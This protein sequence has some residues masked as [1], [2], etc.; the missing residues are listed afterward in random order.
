MLDLPA[1]RATA[2]VAIDLGTAYT[3]L[4]VRGKGMVLEAPSVVATRASAR[5]R[6]VVAI[7]AEAR[8]MLGRA[9]AGITVE[10]PVRGG[11]VANFEATEL[12]I[13]ALL[14]QAGR[15]GLMRPR[16]LVC[17]PPDT[18]DVERRA[19]QESTRAAGA[20]DVVLVGT[21]L[22]A[23]L[24]AGVPVDRP[25]GSIVIDVGAGR[26]D[27]GVVSLGGLV[28]RRSIHVA[29]DVMDVAITDWLRVHHNLLVG[30]RTA[31]AVK[32]R[33]GCAAL[34]GP[35]DTMRVRG[36]DLPTG[37][38]RELDLR[39]SEI[40]DALHHA[41]QAIRA[42]TLEA[43]AQTPPEVSADIIDRGILLAGGGS[44]L[45]GLDAMLRDATGLPVLRAEDA[46]HCVARG[47][48]ALLEQPALFAR[49]VQVGQ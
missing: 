46:A 41:V 7:G 27:V 13:R 11:I 18:T 4:V 48:A 49:M 10:R 44:G 26:T 40:G 22:V 47:A 38:P 14:A 16:V 31:E 39:S 34:V 12:L 6:E 28:V 21:P 8:K 24:G 42:I 20:R 9:P 17:I 30:E 3:R 32:V 35:P 19:V 23:A 33:L 5:G 1:A 45:T 25:T 36:R 2:D 15:S 43:L 29:G 37:S